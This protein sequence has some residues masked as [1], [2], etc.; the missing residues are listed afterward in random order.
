M[1]TW[2]IF[3]WAAIPILIWIGYS[4]E[5]RL[6][7]KE[8]FILGLIFSGIAGVSLWFDHLLGYTAFWIVFAMAA[9]IAIFPSPDTIDTEQTA[10]SSSDVIN[11]YTDTTKIHCKVVS[12]L[13]SV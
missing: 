1:S 8:V 4:K 12:I 7:F 3:A 10:S 9:L 5:T 2:M 13:Q 6:T 11:K